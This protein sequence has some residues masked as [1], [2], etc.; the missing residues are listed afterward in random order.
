MSIRVMIIDE[1]ADFRSL[2][3]HHVTTRWPDAII[4]AYDPTAAGHLPDE[5]SGAGNDV[6]LLG[7]RHGDDRDG[8]DV[9]RRFVKKT[10]FPPVVYFGADDDSSRVEKLGPDAYFQRDSIDHESF[11]E[12]VASALRARH[13]PA[14]P[15][16]SSVG[17]LRS[18][19]HPVIKGYR[20]LR[21]L[22]ATEHSGVYLGE[23]QSNGQLLVLKLLRQM[24]DDAASQ[25]AFDRFLRE[26]EAIAD[27]R[28][29]NIVEIYDLGVSDDHA[30]IAMEYLDN[31][32]LRYRLNSGIDETNAFD[33]LRQIASALSA[34]H[35]RGVLHRDLKPANI[36]LRKDGS[37]A[38]IDFGLAK[39]ARLASAVSDEGEIFGTPFYMSPEQ[40][41]GNR[42]DERSDIYSLGVI[43][44]EMLTGLKPFH[45]D[46]AMGVIYRHAQAPIPQ[47][48]KRYADYQALLERLLAKIPR[49]RL[50]TAVEV[51]RWLQ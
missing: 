37:L 29:R 5:F 2:L 16:S 8:V 51:Q 3:M 11:V 43:F 1:Q 7:D 38:L 31:G 45:A 32:D 4:S 17:D 21:K 12:A 50:Q 6:I 40:G 41:H 48:P 22:S 26:Y 9:L 25:S 14:L 10:G 23:R 34:I 33:Y 19:T 28:H 36:M 27:M 46:T 13:R 18:D 30:Y 44:Y 47:L 15:G 24:S 39:R 20:V 35:S 42:V 49:D